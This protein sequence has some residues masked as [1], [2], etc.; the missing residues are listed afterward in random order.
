M[1][2]GLLLFGVSFA[3]AI[4]PAQAVSIQLDPKVLS[5]VETRTGL[6]EVE[7]TNLSFY[8]LGTPADGGGFEA[9]LEIEPDLIRFRNGGVGLGAFSI[10]NSTTRLTLDVVNDTTEAVPFSSFSSVIIPAGFGYFIA[11]LGGDCSP[12]TPTGCSLLPPRDSVSFQNIKRAT[13][14]PPGVELGRVGF[15]FQVLVDGS[16]SYALAASLRLFFDPITNTNIFFEDFGDAATVLNG[17]TLASVPGDQGVL[18]YAWDETPFSFALPNPVLAAGETRSIVY[19]STV[20]VETYASNPNSALSLLGYSAFGDPIG[21]PGGGGT[22]DFKSLLA[23][24]LAFGGNVE[25]GSFEFVLPF[26]Q[27]GALFLPPAGGV[28]PEPSTWAMLI[29]G[30]GLVGMT[31]RRRRAAIA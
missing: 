23:E 24:S 20:F 29:A 7:G 12:L 9:S 11:L 13:D 22:D 15:D 8:Q 30:F 4:S 1:K 6:T 2:L 3:C 14:L 5:S 28:I 31:A 25:I 16:V 17:F 10:I 26:L 19:V 18:G 27:D 21:R